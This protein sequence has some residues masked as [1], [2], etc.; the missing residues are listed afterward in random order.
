V[1]SFEPGMS[2]R[3]RPCR[4]D[5]APERR[6]QVNAFQTGVPGCLFPP[7]TGEILFQ[8]TKI[9]NQKPWDLCRKGLARTFQIVKTLCL[10][11]VLYNVMVGRVCDH[12]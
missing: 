11:T 9:N 12:G 1:E 6:R 10:A 7:T 3:E 8:G 2:S 4:P 5:S